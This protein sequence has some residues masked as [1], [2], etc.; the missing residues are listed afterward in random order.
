MNPIP[1]TI[2]A[3]LPALSDFRDT[4]HWLAFRGWSEA[5]GG[6]MSVRGIV[7]KGFAET[8]YQPL[9][10]QVPELAG[11][12]L[13]LTGSGTR[14]REIG[15]DPVPHVGLY[16]IGADAKSY[17][18][19]AGN[20]KPTMELAA[21]CA[22]HNQLEAVRP[23]DKAI[24]HTHPASL[25]ALCHLDGFDSAQNISKKIL[26]LQS[27]AWLHLPEGVGFVEQQLPGS[28]ALGLASAKAMRQHRLVLWQYHGLLAS[29]TSLAHAVDLMEVFEKAAQVYWQIRN[30]GIEPAGIC[31]QETR[32]TLQAFGQLDRY[33]GGDSLPE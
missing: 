22:I 8:S 17:C 14:A 25:I 1:N 24:V 10:L 13:L 16:K 18:W 3:E 9:P 6:N 7:P 4:A 23:D 21:H 28:L 32:N 27:E 30:V 15:I 20:A 11:M 31:E 29:G 33:A 5:A 26:C 19:L 12:A 2:F